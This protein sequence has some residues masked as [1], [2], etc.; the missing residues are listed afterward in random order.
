VTTI[1]NTVVEDPRLLVREAEW[2]SAFRKSGS[3]TGS[4]A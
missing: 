1:F 4:V 3:E 2:I